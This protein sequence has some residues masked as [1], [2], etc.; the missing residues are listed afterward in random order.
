M[1]KKGI[2]LDHNISAVGIEVD[3]S[4]VDL[5]LSLLIPK[6]VRDIRAFLGHAGFYRRF[7]KDFSKITRTLTH[8]LGKDILFEFT[9]PCHSTFEQLKSALTT[10]PIIHSPDWNLPFEIMCDASDYAVGAV[11][12]QKVEKARHVI[13]YA[14]KTLNDAQTNYSTTGERV[15]D[16]EI[17]DKK[18]SD[19]VVADHLSRLVVESIT[20][21]IP[22]SNAFA[23]EQ[24]FAITH[25]PWCVPEINQESV[26]SFCHDQACGG[27]F[28]CK[29]IA[30]KILQ[31]GFYWPTLFK[32]TH[33]YYMACQRYQLLGKITKRNEWPQQPV[34]VVEIFD[35][36]GI[37]FMGPFPSSYGCLY[38]LL[39]VDYVS[40]WVEA[41]AT[42]AT[43]HRVVVR[44][45]KDLILPRFGI[46]RA[47]ISDNGSHFCNKVFGN[48]LTKYGII[49]K[50]ALSYHP[51]TNSQAKAYRTTYKTP[52]G[53]SLY[54]LVYGKACH[55][56]VELEHC[57][58]WAIKAMNF[59]SN[60]AGEHRKLQLDELEEIRND[61]YESSKMY[62]AKTKFEHDKHILRKDF[63]PGQKV[64]LY[65]SCLQLFPGKLQSCW[66]SPY[67]VKHVASH[68]AIEVQ[69]PTTGELFEVNAHRL[70]PFLELES[71]K[72]E[73][74]L[75]IDPVYSD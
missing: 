28:S 3:Q 60:K 40:K 29:R 22:I 18:G 62:K 7:I 27:H 39:A 44:F 63:F 56:P 9:D 52:I 71:H 64:L 31:S 53:M 61:A 34:L 72:I 38:I 26:I 33:I 1:V 46:P 58:Y 8:L 16:F 54:H 50:V 42:K 73:E 13:Y 48:L 2:V 65:N 37:D 21:S 30:A 10:A 25:A 43:D 23:D 24:L 69:D 68:G 51:Q 66:S 49:H 4:K 11:L 19:N 47:I 57:A 14:S 35:V 55:L 32:D 67:F 12:G 59:D 70:K 45:F 5:I 75:L 20:K 41:L 17:C 36:W 15:F 74:I 6:T